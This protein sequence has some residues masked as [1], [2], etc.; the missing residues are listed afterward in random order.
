[1]K[2]R[3]LFED[4]EANLISLFR[5]F[6][7]SF[8]SG[9][10]VISESDEAVTMI[11]ELLNDEKWAE[12]VNNSANTTNPPDYYYDNGKIML[13]VMRVDDHARTQGNKL[14]NPYIKKQ[15]EVE[16][17][18]RENGGL[19]LAPTAPIFVNTQTD[20]PSNNDHNYI[21]YRDNFKRVVEKHIKRI[22]EYRLNHPGY[23]LIFFVYDES[24]IYYEADTPNKTV[25]P[26][27]PFK[28]IPHFW[29]ADRAFADII[30]NADID[31]LIW[32]T[33]YKIDWT[34]ISTIG[35]NIPAAGI[36]DC[37]KMPTD[38]INYPAEYM[39]SIE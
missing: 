16:Q 14:V 11:N 31:F 33:P 38:T 1:M 22:P 13:E 36:F 12:W 21:F 20:L 26:G 9:V 32:Y 29:Y 39:F 7:K 4:D 24:T 17:E 5:A 37:K 6:A 34:K 25:K 18:M 19:P 30:T 27:E 8:S 28:Y 2:T 15:R 23:K 10:R 3:M 35:D